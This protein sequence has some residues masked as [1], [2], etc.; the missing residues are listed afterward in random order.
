MSGY[1]IF[2][3]KELDYNKEIKINTFINNKKNI[4]YYNIC[5]IAVALKYAKKAH[6][7]DYYIKKNIKYDIN[8][9]YKNEYVSLDFLHL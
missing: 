9:V 4:T 5:D 7:R 2:T 8:E 1:D 3:A 6:L